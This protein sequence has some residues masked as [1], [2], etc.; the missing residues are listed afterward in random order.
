MGHSAGTTGELTRTDSDHG[1]GPLDW[2]ALSNMSRALAVRGVL[3]NIE[4]R[5]YEPRHT[6]ATSLTR[7]V[8]ETRAAQRILI[9]QFNTPMER[10][11]HV[12][13]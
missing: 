2:H 1:G 11:P 5:L 13:I 9:I 10:L 4:V 7:S 12:W 8:P 6:F 3:I